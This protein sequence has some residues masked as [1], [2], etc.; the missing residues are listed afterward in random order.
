MAM[1]NLA[2]AKP[3]LD[4]IQEIIQREQPYTFLWESQRMPAIN[5][6]LHDVK[7]NMLFALAN[8]KE[9]WIEPHP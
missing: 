8:M 1:T 7:P 2:D 9:W 4:R 5:R 3:I 6:R